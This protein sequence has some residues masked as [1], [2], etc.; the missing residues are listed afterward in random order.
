MNQNSTDTLDLFQIEKDLIGTT[1]PIEKFIAIKG[2]KQHESEIIQFVDNKLTTCNCG[3]WNKR[4]EIDNR[5]N[6][7]SVDCDI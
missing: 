7:G 6:C 5:G 4:E 2:L 3:F 1:H